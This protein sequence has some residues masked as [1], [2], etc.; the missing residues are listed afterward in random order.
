VSGQDGGFPSGGSGD[1]GGSGVGLEGAC[2]GEAGVVVAEFGQD[3]GAGEVAEAGEAG[4]DLGVLVSGEGVEERG[5]QFVGAGA[6]GVELSQQGEGFGAHRVLDQGWLAHLGLAQQGV[7]AFDFAG[8]FAL[9]A[10]LFEDGPQLGAGELGGLC[11]CGGR[12]E[13]GAADG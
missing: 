10:G 2:G 7:E 8:D 6:G 1:G 12:G 13:Q 3:A 5:F 4:D 9:A 11:G